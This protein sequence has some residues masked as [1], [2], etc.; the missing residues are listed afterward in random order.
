MH[1][2]IADAVLLFYGNQFVGRPKSWGFQY[3]KISTLSQGTGV[4]RI[5]IMQRT[6][7]SGWIW[8]IRAVGW[9]RVIGV[10]VFPQEHVADKQGVGLFHLGQQ[11]RV[12]KED[13][14]LILGRFRYVT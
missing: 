11:S 5:P 13:V 1:V 2:M 9:Q 10:F 3:F 12:A 14:R 4:V 6:Y 8:K 7:W